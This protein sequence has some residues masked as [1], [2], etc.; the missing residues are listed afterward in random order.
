MALAP[1]P[2]PAP[3]RPRTRSGRWASLVPYL[4]IAPFF[5]LF[6]VFG[7]FPIGYT[8]FISLFEWN[9]IG[10]K[11]FLGAD[12]YTTLLADPRFWN[13]AANT[14]SIW[15]ISTIP[16]LIFAAVLAA[17]LNHAR[18]RLKTPLRMA[19]LVPNVTSVIA[20]GIIF[21]QIFGRDYGLVNWVVTA[22]GG[23]RI[24]WASGSFTSH[25]AI[26]SMVMWRWTGYNTLIFLAAMQSIPKSLY[27]S[28]SIDG[29]GGVRQFLS[30]TIP[31][32]R[33]TIIFAVIISTIGGLQVFAEPLVFSGQGGAS[34]GSSRQFQTLA[35]FLYEQGFRNFDFGYASAI[36][37][38]LFVI[39]TVI[40]L[41]NLKLTSRIASDS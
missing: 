27:D 2:T 29:A 28:A 13:A 35:L 10:D 22:L 21:T 40:T 37:W 41:I 1:Q 12:N 17:V 26:S 19:V 6:G 33:P 11:V 4:Y 15:L 8:L 14:L 23:E 31:Q 38:A 16:Q 24:D 30:I 18:L 36:A 20:V 39:V 34:G 9:P 3:P 5:L 32:L 7:V 25:V